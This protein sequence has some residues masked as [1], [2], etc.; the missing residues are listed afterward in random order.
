LRKTFLTYFVVLCS[1]I[2]LIGC[3]AHTPQVSYPPFQSVDLDSK[4]SSGGYRQKADNFVAIMDASRSVGD[5]ES[6]RTKFEMARNFL[7]RANQSLP[8]IPVSSALR[9]FG[10]W[11]IRDGL[12]TIL[13]YGPTNWNRAEFQA[14]LDTVT[15]GAGAS[16]VDQALDNS[17][18]DMA[19]MTGPTA[20]ILVGDGKYDTAAAVAAAERMKT[21]YDENVC[22]YTVLVGT[23]D[24][25]AVQTMTDIANA[26]GCGFNAAAGELES[27][28]AMA[29]WVES[30]FWA[31]GAA[32]APM[33]SD[34]DGV[35]DSKDACPDTPRG[36]T[37]DSKGCPLDSDGDGVYDYLDKCPATPKGAT[38]DA[39]GCWV[40]KG[41]NFNTG[42]S[43][44]K[45]VS[46][47]F[48]DEVAAILIN[49]PALKV[50]IQGHTD[51][52][53]SAAFN[54]KLSE[55]RANA[56]LDYLVQRG[57]PRNRLAA[58]GY[59]FSRPAAS[60]STPEGRAQNR[61]V[62]LKPMR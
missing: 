23:A 32:P 42:E 26:G 8:D 31:K 25:D 10:H 3:Q 14:A 4:L 41:I 6:G 13:H 24:A 48:L 15:W 17:S 59:G 28:Q 1:S 40:V 12:Q 34:G 43:I 47:R 33:D 7:Y 57:V 62:E 5:T 50:E 22:I 54:Q 27:P 21:R 37:V 18:Q 45:P 49:N 35:V 39:R 2:V 30:V 61:R 52:R 36:V 46:H 16:P 11:R 9:S 55:N 29:N 53:G 60:N 20:V 51:N 19:S 56:V 38:V 58:I 44:I